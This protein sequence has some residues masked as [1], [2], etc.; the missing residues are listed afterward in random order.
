MEVGIN[1]ELFKLYVSNVEFAYK[2]GSSFKER[3]SYHLMT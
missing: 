2:D 3:N 1:V